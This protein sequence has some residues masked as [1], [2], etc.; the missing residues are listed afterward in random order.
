MHTEHLQNVSV[1]RVVAGWLVAAA[2]ASMVVLALLGTGLMD[3]ETTATNTWWSVFAVGAGFFAGG[4][5]A[6]F[7]ALQAPVLHGV[8]IGI[9]SLVAWFL[10]T[11]LSALL[12]TGG[13]QWPAVTT[14]FTA[15]V[16]FL[17]FATAVLGALMGYNLATRGRP[18]LGEHEPV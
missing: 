2:V 7:R 13:W 5:F 17:Q 16:L 1:G 10:V 12:V 3:D 18:G 9:T 8:G 6:G 4:F 11:A 14:S 15:G